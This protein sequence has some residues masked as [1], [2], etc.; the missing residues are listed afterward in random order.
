MQR[1]YLQVAEKGTETAAVTGI[2]GM[3]VSAEV[4]KVP[5]I[6]FDHPFLFL[7]RDTT[8]GTILFASAMANPVG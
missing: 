8:T 4:P 2:S 5:T 6:T 1:T 7:I 3:I